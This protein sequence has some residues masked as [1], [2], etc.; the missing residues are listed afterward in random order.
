MLRTM[1]LCRYVQR[2]TKNFVVIACNARVLVYEMLGSTPDSSRLY[3]WEQKDGYLE[4]QTGRKVHTLARWV[5]YFD[6]LTLDAV[7]ADLEKW[8]YITRIQR[9]N[10]QLWVW[11]RDGY[12]HFFQA[13]PFGVMDRSSIAITTLM[14][15]YAWVPYE[16]E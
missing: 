14:G 12:E 10:D 13:S 1:D 6:V 16:F 2:R 8:G 7:Q 5:H 15:W 4:N 11:D 9:E 3:I